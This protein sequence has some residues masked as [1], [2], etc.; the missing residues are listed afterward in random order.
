MVEE[1][2]PVYGYEDSYEVSSQGRVRSLSR[3]VPHY[4]GG[5]SVLPERILLSDK[6]NARGYLRFTLSQGGQTR[7]I[8]LHRMVCQSFHGE[9]PV[10]K[11][12]ACHKDGNPRNNT[13]GNVYWGSHADNMRDK[14][15]HGTNHELN[16]T[17]CP[18][19]HPYKG[20]NL[21]IV[22]KTGKRQCRAC[23]KARRG[24]V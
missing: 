22:P 12:L 7:R 3:P 16:K 24:G 9:N 4:R 14:I 10:D 21:Y 11:P 6:S 2:T 23:A 8:S 18:S 5:T 1:W 17:H 20:D 15:L 19:G 13:P